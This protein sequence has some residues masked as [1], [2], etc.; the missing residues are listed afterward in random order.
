[1]EFPFC[2]LLKVGRVGFMKH[3]IMLTVC[4]GFNWTLPT[5]DLQSTDSLYMNCK[6][7][8]GVPMCCSMIGESDEVRYENARAGFRQSGMYHRKLRKSDLRRG[9]TYRLC[10]EESAYIPSSYELDQMKTAA[11]IDNLNDGKA[12]REKFIEFITS[13]VQ[14]NNSFLWLTRVMERQRN[15]YETP[16]TEQMEIDVKYLSRFNRSLTCDGDVVESW[17]DWIEPISVHCRNPY[18]LLTCLHK[19]NR[20]PPL[21]N[22]HDLRSKYPKYF[23]G[24]LNVTGEQNIDYVLVHTPHPFNEF[25]KRKRHTSQIDTVK[26]FS[27]S[28]SILLDAGTSSYSSSLVWLNCIYM[29]HNISFDRIFGWESSPLEPTAFWDEVPKQ[30]RAK[31]HFYNAPMSSNITHGNSPLRIIKQLAKSED[32]VSFKLDIDSP[33][34][35]VPT[36]LQLLENPTLSALVDEFFFE[37]H[38]QCGIMA[39]CGWG[40]TPGVVDGLNM[41]RTSAMELFRD[42]RKLGIRSHFWP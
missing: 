30:I 34:V 14:L 12:A 38:F 18:S 19:Y 39:G 41:S 20:N 16:T 40:K 26:H 6:L 36:V 7:P 2:N 25:K 3:A 31:Y 35:E 15:P 32:F 22:V 24:M 42:L 33:L 21:I 28:K 27:S 17:V 5:G 29:Q 10:H 4:Y 8:S 9:S 11:A 1:M 13:E 37:L 23:L